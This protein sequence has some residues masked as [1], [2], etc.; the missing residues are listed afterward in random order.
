MA[1]TILFCNAN[2]RFIAFMDPQSKF[3]YFSHTFYCWRTLKP[4]KKCLKSYISRELDFPKL[5][6]KANSR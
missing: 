1:E 3:K 5:K 4:L 6:D 2:E